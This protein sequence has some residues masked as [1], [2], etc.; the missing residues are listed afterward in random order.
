MK[1]KHKP[2][3]KDHFWYIQVSRS[4]SRKGIRNWRVVNMAI[5][6]WEHREIVCCGK[7]HYFHF[8]KRTVTNFV[9]RGRKH[10]ILEYSIS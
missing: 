5:H 9:K 1:R 2:T 3:D 8:R 4:N 6:Y 10:G 7:R